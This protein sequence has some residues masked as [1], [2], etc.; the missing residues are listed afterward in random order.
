M[1]TGGPLWRGRLG[2]WKPGSPRLIGRTLERLKPRLWEPRTPVLYNLTVRA[3]RSGKELDSRAVRFGFRSFENRDGGFTLNGRPFFLRGLA[4]NPPGRGIPPEVGESRSFARDY[5]RFLKSRNVNILRLE[6]DS[7]TWFDV[8]DEEGMLIYQGRYGAPFGAEGTS[9][10][11]D[12]EASLKEYR[13]AF[14][15]YTRHPAIVIYVLSNE[16][17]YTGRRGELFHQFLGR[18]FDRLR[19]WDPTRL[20]IA[21][22]GYGEGRE[23]D[24]RDVHRYWGWYY[25]T[26]LTYYNLRDPNLYGE[27]SKKQPFTFSECVGCFTG[28]YGEFNIIERK[29]LGPQLNWT[30][31]SPEQVRDALAYQAFMVRQAAESFRRLRSLNPHLAG[32]MPFT[33][34]FYHWSGIRSFAQMKAKPALEQMGIS[35]QPV[36]LSWECWTGQVYAGRKV[37][38]RAHVINDAD[39]GSRL[40]GATLSCRLHGPDGRPVLTRR[41]ELPAVP[42]FGTWSAPLALDLPETLP[43]GDY[44]LRGTLLRAGRQVSANEM[45]LF[46]AGRDWNPRPTSEKPIALYDPAGK[47]AAALKRLGIPCTPVT[48]PATVAAGSALVIGEEAWDARLSGARE[49]LARFIREGG[50]VLCLGQEPGKWDPGWFPAPI[51]PLKVS[52][53]APTYP[54]PNRPFRENMNVNP[55]RP[56]HPVFEGI[57][58]ARLSLWSDYTGWDETKPG[59]PRLYPVTRGV[60]LTD[61]ASLAGTAVLANYDQGLQGVALCEAFDGKGS[62][63][64]CGLDLVSRSGL[65]PIADRMLANLV[66][67]TASN[68]GHSAYPLVKHPIQWGRYGTEQGVITGPLHGMVVNAAWVPPPTNPHA[69]PPESPGWNTHPGDQFAPHGRRLLGPFGY[70][71]GGG[72]RDLHPAETSASGSLWVRV[73]PGRTRIVTRVENPSAQTASLTVEI[74][75]KPAG[76]PASIPSR[77]TVTLQAPLPAGQ[78]ELAVRY[79]GSKSLALL[80]TSFE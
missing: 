44:T 1:G 53:N 4:I 9:P 8:C 50:R 49:G 63:I 13:D 29:Q 3:V 10:P 66:R 77:Q 38:V 40:E 52:P 25:N 7:Q 41:L 46:V 80:E 78:T 21:N 55:E 39:D 76:S 64:L 68:A 34:P 12:I 71:A 5:I 33:I 59:F 74:N 28:P 6:H 35:Y 31:H 79:T 73:P 14:S 18:A 75:G 24:V 47:T 62:A 48:E 22:A 43:T 72:V 51:E 37:T 20:Y 45:R 17:P 23:G 58:G 67:Y 36:L 27:P 11:R 65:D 42:Y 69:S 61:P 19:E 26:F 57:S 15:G 56:G 70:S 2:E 30:G 54:A 32:L 16:Q 60:R